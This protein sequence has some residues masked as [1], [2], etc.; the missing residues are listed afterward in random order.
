MREIILTSPETRE[1]AREAISHGGIEEAQ[2]RGIHIDEIRF[3]HPNEVVL[4]DNDKNEKS[5]LE[6]A[7]EWLE[8]MMIVA[9]PIWVYQLR[10]LGV[11]DAAL[12]QELSR[13]RNERTR[14]NQ[15]RGCSY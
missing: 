8:A 15:T 7:R 10:T 9:Y 5:K 3:P 2:R 11:H 14:F 1:I 12:W 6:E 4:F 13:E